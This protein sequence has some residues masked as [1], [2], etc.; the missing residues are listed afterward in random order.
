MM[1]SNE[2]TGTVIVLDTAAEV[3]A[4]ADLREP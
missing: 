4:G 1:L 3:E 2:Y